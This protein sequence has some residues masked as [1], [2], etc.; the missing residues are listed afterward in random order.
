[1]L[2]MPE[3]RKTKIPANFSKYLIDARNDRVDPC[4]FLEPFFELG[5]LAY[6]KYVTIL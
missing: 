2:N 3:S 5:S 6:E 4:A 1:M